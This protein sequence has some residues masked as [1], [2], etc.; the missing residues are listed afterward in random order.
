MKI[1]RLEQFYR[2]HARLYN[3]T[4]HFFLI[5]RQQAI[6]R[7][8]IRSDHLIVEY[9]CG[10]GLNAPLMLAKTSPDHIIGIDYTASMLSIARARNPW[11]KLIRGDVAKP[12]LVPH[13]VDRILCTYAVSMVEEWQQALVQM[14]RALKEDGLLVILDFQPWEGR[15]KPLYPLF[16]WWLNRHGVDP[17]QPIVPFLRQHFG[18]VELLIRHHGYNAIISAT[19]PLNTEHTP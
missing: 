1:S 14:K 5:D 13:S 7:L 11:L 18:R 6:E 8:D 9:A 10:T 12:L 4:R 19:S 15:F 16:R 17:E 2:I 3:P